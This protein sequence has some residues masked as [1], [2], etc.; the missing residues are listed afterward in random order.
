M[1]KEPAKASISFYYFDNKNYL[2]G[3]L[4]ASFMFPSSFKSFCFRNKFFL[5]KYS[6]KLYLIIVSNLNFVTK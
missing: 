5:T 3:I 2:L 4:N 6:F 1:K